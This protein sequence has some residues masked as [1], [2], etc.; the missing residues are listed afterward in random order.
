MA[1]M[2]KGEECL[3]NILCSSRESL[4]DV[5][6]MVY[7]GRGLPQLCENIISELLT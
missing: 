4:M 5:A 7:Y 1:F 3:V 2:D 6:N